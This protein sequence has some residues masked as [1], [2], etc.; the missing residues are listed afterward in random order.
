MTLC[1][2]LRVFLKVIHEAFLS[3]LYLACL[4]SVN[5]FALTAS[6]PSGWKVFAQVENQ[7]AQVYFVSP[8]G[9]IM[10]RSEQVQEFL[11]HTSGDFEHKDPRKGDIIE[12]EMENPVK[13]GEIEW[14]KGVVKKANLQKRTF[15][16]VFNIQEADE[17]GCWEEEYSVSLVS[18][19]ASALTCLCRWMLWMNGGGQS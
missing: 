3:L 18:R 2:V 11:Q 14:V 15:K 4:F 16:V 17:E 12:A 6:V 10:T 7:T 5:F 13:D 19:T 8:C 1:T 9:K